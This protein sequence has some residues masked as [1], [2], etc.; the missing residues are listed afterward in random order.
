MHRARNKMF[1]Q[2]KSSN[3]H[4]RKKKTDNNK[5]TT[6]QEQSLSI[7]LNFYTLTTG[8]KDFKLK[9]IESLLTAR[10]KS[11]LNKRDF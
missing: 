10:D 4:W 5:V 6:I 3:N 2:R 1:Q 8:S 7:L 9:V 11:V